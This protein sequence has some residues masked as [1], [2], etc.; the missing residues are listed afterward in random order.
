MYRFI[1]ESLLGVHIQANKLN[2]KPCLP[3]DWKQFTLRYRYRDTFYVIAVRQI[4]TAES[5]A[6]T[7]TVTVDGIEQAEPVITLVDDRQDHDVEIRI[8]ARGLERAEGDD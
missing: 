5:V 7:T 4:E 8:S 3:P 6:G 1:V 2:F